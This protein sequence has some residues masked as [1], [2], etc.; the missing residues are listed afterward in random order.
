[1]DSLT[2]GAMGFCRQSIPHSAGLGTS[3][4]PTVTTKKPFL[5]TESLSD[6]VD[7]GQAKSSHWREEVC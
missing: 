5:L 3:V 6:L 4:A 7:E 2:A 1:M